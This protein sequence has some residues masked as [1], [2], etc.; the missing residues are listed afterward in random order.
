VPETDLWPTTLLG[1]QPVKAAPTGLAAHRPTAQAARQP[2]TWACRR[3]HRCAVT[4]AGTVARA[5]PAHRLARCSSVCGMSTPGVKATRRA[6][7]GSGRLT[8]TVARHEDGGGGPVQ[9]WAKAVVVLRCA[10]RL[11]EE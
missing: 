1:Q 3:A 8:M 7:R 10:L 11:E 6:T 2:N 4:A 5:T 9:R